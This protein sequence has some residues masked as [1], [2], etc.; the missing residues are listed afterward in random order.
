MFHSSWLVH[1][2][3][4][5]QR[6]YRFSCISQ[7]KAVIFFLCFILFPGSPKWKKTK[8]KLLHLSS[9][10]Q[11]Y[12]IFRYSPY[13]AWPDNPGEGLAEMP[14]SPL[15]SPRSMPPDPLPLLS[16]SSAVLPSK[17][18]S[19]LCHLDFLCS[20]CFLS[21]FQRKINHQH[22]LPNLP[23]IAQFSFP[24]LLTIAQLPCF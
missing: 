9:K 17:C 12:H 4:C 2:I 3:M 16:K 15:S 7:N 13:K 6:L 18:P 20:S 22:L 11:P 10:I 1:L 14:P 24:S 8:R 23:D 21:A 5:G 19:L